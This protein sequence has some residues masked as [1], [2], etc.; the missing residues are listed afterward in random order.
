MRD[1]I[2]LWGKP[3]AAGQLIDIRLNESGIS[4]RQIDFIDKNDGKNAQPC[5][6][7]AIQIPDRNSQP[8]VF[9]TSVR[10]GPSAN[11]QYVVPFTARYYQTTGSGSAN[12][13]ATFTVEYQ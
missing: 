3:E 12:D 10:V 1:F 9:G 2:Y 13:T 11:I 6:T 8:F 4:Q 7:R 5:L